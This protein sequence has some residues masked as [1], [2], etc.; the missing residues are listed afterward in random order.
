M[1]EDGEED[2]VEGMLWM[3]LPEKAIMPTCLVLFSVMFR[4]QLIVWHFQIASK[5][6]M[7]HLRSTKAKIQLVGHW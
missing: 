4:C 2:R 7:L 6:L 5:Y 1:E 3:L